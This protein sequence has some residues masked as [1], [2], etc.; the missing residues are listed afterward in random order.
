MRITQWNRSL[1]HSGCIG[2]SVESPRAGS[3]GQRWVVVRGCDVPL[4][5][6]AQVELDS[7]KSTSASTSITPSSH[8]ASRLLHAQQ[9]SKEWR[10]ELCEEPCHDFE[11]AVTLEYCYNATVP[12]KRAVHARHPRC[13]DVIA[14]TVGVATRRGF[15]AP[16]VICT[17]AVPW[18]KRVIGD[19]GARRGTP[20]AKSCV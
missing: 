14:V 9:S 8:R 10:K 17:A 18:K 20:S 4:Y 12:D 5:F 6:A 3:A 2:R 1:E 16:L 11:D 15:A 7:S 13:S 19:R